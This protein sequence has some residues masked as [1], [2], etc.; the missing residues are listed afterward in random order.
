MK[1]FCLL[2][3]TLL[4]I[5][6]CGTLPKIDRP[7]GRIFPQGFADCR[8][9]FLPGR[10]QFQHAI[11]ATLPGG[12]KSIL[13]GVSVVSSTNGSIH[14]ILLTVEGLVVFDAEFDQ[15][16]RVLRALPPFDSEHFAQ[17]LINDIRLIFL[18]PEGPLAESGTLQNGSPICRYR[19]PDKAVVDIV[20]NSERHWTLR[21]YDRWLAKKRTVDFFFNDSFR[22]DGLQTP[23]RL[24]LISH[25]FDG[26]T[27]DMDLIEAVSLEE[28][29]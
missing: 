20:K 15:G 9:L 25:G 7:D 13:M 22:F 10:W 1:R 17:G 23:V 5:A 2:L 18:M 21:Q 19:Q 29:K 27:L 12:K 8:R 11:E 28:H 14:C 16:I 24:K 6:A 3:G 26:Y 4:L